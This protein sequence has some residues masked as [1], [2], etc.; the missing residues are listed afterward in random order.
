MLHNKYNNNIKNMETIIGKCSNITIL[1]TQKFLIRYLGDD[2]KFGC[3]KYMF[4]LY[5]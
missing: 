3:R 2:N 5:Y 1:D 4:F